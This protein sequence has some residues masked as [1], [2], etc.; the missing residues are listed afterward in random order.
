MLLGGRRLQRKKVTSEKTLECCF[1]SAS[2]SLSFRL[3]GN[4]SAEM[5]AEPAPVP[6]EMAAE[7]APPTP[8]LGGLSPRQPSVVL[9]PLQ[10]ITQQFEE[11]LQKI[12]G[13]GTVDEDGAGPGEEAAAQWYGD[14]CN[15]A[16]FDAAIAIVRQQ[17]ALVDHPAPGTARNLLWCACRDC[18]SRV[19]KDLLSGNPPANVHALDEGA[20]GCAEIPVLACAVQEDVPTALV[21]AEL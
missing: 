15:A 14:E 5:A 20:N 13:S 1:S 4:A 12:I 18:N 3:A 17:P 10:T 19:V 2:T 9:P 7:P 21:C 16:L 11:A 8:A 6:G